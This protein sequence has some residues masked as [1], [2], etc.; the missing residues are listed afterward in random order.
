[1]VELLKQPQYSPMNVIDQIFSIY[2][3]TRGHLDKVPLDQVQK[4]E[5]DFLEFVHRERQDLWDKVEKGGKLT[6]EISDGIKK[7]IE[8]FASSYTIAGSESESA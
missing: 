2:A 8:D 6:D 3:G 1:M 7:A 4:W 5:K